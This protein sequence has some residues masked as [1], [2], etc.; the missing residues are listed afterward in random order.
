M[1]HEK[2]D[3]NQYISFINTPINWSGK[4]DFIFEDSN[5]FISTEQSLANAVDNHLLDIPLERKTINI[6]IICIIQTLSNK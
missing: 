4:V 3:R 5:I 1:I 2:I 6:P